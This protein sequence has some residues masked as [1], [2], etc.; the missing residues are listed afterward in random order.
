MPLSLSLAAAGIT[1][2]KT[3]TFGFDTRWSVHEAFRNDKEKRDFISCG[4]AAGVSAAF[5]A[6]VSAA[7]LR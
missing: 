2:G 7:E 5:G 4:A 6:P 1:Q 3:R